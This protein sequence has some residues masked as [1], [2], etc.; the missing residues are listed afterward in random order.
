MR[1]WECRGKDNRLEFHFLDYEEWDSIECLADAL[2]RHFEAQITESIDG[3]EN[4]RIRRLQIAGVELTLVSSDMNGT[5]L[6]GSGPG[7]EE[8]TRRVV[9]DLPGILG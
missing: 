1:V 9:R 5:Y 4:T 6:F 8:V 2:V 7:A 3:P